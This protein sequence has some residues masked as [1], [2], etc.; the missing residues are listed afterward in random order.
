MGKNQRIVVIGGSSGMGLEVAKY[1][2]KNG[3]DVVI[4]SRSKEK[5]EKARKE[6]GE[7]EIHVLDLMVE[8]KIA[9]F[10]SKVGLFD[11]L[12]TP[13]ADFFMGPF[14]GGTTEEAR[15]YFDSKFWGQYR[16][17]RYGAA[18]I[19]KGGSITLFSGAANQKPML[20]FSAGCAINAAVEGLGRALA[21]ELSPIRVNTISPGVIVSPLWNMMSKEERVTFFA[22]VAE[23]LPAKRVGYPEDIAKAVHYLIECNYATGSVVH[24]DGGYSLV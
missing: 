20:N 16:A 15:K 22:Q 6:I 17:A 3:Y 1:M 8:S 24:V 9:D 23:K 12:V 4:A 11:H 2:H 19:R 14:L 10:F 13:A 5:L 18:H 7:A 21:L